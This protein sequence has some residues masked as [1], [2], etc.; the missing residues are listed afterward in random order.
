MA[1]VVD[2]LFLWMRALKR[3]Y[4]YTLAQSYC[5]VTVV[6]AHKIITVVSAHKKALK[7]L[8]NAIANH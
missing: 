3:V 7:S 2:V 4:L 8:L 1:W 6:S 5:S